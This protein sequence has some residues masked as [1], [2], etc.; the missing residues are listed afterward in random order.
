MLALLLGGTTDAMS[1]AT[2][3]FDCGTEAPSPGSRA[4][5]EWFPVWPP[6]LVFRWRLLTVPAWPFLCARPQES[7]LG[8]LPL[9]VRTTV[10]LD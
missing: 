9:L 10:L 3:V 2:N 6:S 4:R 5:R 1:E 8:S 7:P